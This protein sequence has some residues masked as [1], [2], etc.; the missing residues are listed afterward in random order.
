MTIDPLSG[1][2]HLDETTCWELLASREVGRLA[3]SIAGEPDIFPVNYVLDGASLVFRTAEG[4]NLAATIMHPSVAFE[5]DGYDAE[6]GVAW[7]VVVRGQAREISMHELVD[8]SAFLLFPW[9]ASPKNRF[10]RI[11]AREVTG[12]RFTVAGRAVAPTELI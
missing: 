6:A 10:V 1:I 11:I 9:N 8:E 3:L 7:S 2:S 4:T 5:T 12:R